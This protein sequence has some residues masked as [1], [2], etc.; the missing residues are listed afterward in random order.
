MTGRRD[1][2]AQER[3]SEAAMLARTR[4]WRGSSRK[5]EEV[6]AR[7]EWKERGVGREGQA[8]E[9]VMQLLGGTGRKPRAAAADRKDTSCRE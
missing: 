7:R 4:G 3:G 5:G 1:A 6:E 8:Q 9:K 2:Q